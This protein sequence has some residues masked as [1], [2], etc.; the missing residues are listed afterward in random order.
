MN[1][2]YT[3][4]MTTV[5]ARTCSGVAAV[6]VLFAFSIA[7]F[8]AVA[9]DT[10]SE[11][12]DTSLTSSLADFGASLFDFGTTPT[13]ETAEMT[14][15]GSSYSHSSTK[16]ECK[17]YANV[18]EV[19]SGGAVTISW[20]T[21]GLSQIT[22]NGETVT[23][24]TGSKTFTNITSDTLFTLFGKSSKGSTCTAKVTVKCLPPPPAPKPECTLT[25]NPWQI[26]KGESTTLV[27]TTKNAQSVTITSFG[28]VEL[29]GSRGTGALTA[30]TTYTLTATGNGK[31]VKCYKTITVV[32]KPVPPSCPISPAPGRTIVNFGTNVQLR[33]DI[34]NQH[35]SNV[36]NVT[37][38]AGDYD[39]RLVSYDG[40]I[41]R[42]S[43]T[44][45]KEQYFV[46]FLNGNNVV[47][48]SQSISDLADYVRQATNNEKVNDALAIGAI[49]GVRAV[50]TVAG[51]TSSANSVYPICM[52]I[53]EKPKDPVPTCDS[54]TA[55]PATLT[56]GQSATLAWQTTNATRVVINNGVGEVSAT[57]TISVAPLANT[58]YTLTV[59]GAK[60]TSATCT[61]PV[62]VIEK[63]VPI[64]ESFTAAP[65]QIPFAGGTTT[66]SWSVKNATEVSISPTVGAV[67]QT[68]TTPVFVNT[69]TTFVLTATSSDGEQ[70]S[71][72]AIV[73]RE[74]EPE[75]F[76][77]ENNVTFS[78]ANSSVRRG[79]S[80]TLSWNV[81]SADS[82]SISVINATSFTGTQSVA[83]NDTTTYVLSATKGSKTVECPVT[84]SVTT[85]GG[86]G[87]S[88][89]PRCELTVS[90]RTITRGQEIVLRWDSTRASDVTITDDRGTVLITTAGKT[91]SEKRTLL[92]GLL[93]L[94]PTRD[95][96]Y[97]MVASQ[98]SRNATCKVKVTEDL[99]VLQ[100]RDQQ[101]LV[102]GISLSSVPYTGFEAGP[103][104]TFMFYAL[105]VA[106]ALYI[107]YLIV[108]RKRG[109]AAT[110]TV[111]VTPNVAAMKQAES[112]RPDVFTPVAAAVT[113]PANLPT[114]TPVIG[115]ANA[116]EAAP[117]PEAVITTTVTA[118]ENRAHQQRALLSS[119]AIQYFITTTEGSIE[120][121]EALD[122]VIAEA[123]KS[124]PLEDGWM[125][126]NESR[127][128]NLCTVCN[129]NA[130][131]HTVSATTIPQGSSSL[132]EA[133]V[134]GNVVAAYEMIGN[135]PMFA[136]ADAATDLDAVYRNRRGE[137]KSV[138]DLLTRESA[139]LSDEA[140]KNMIAALTSALDGT[141]TD[142]ASAVKMAI[143]KAIK[144]SQ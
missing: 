141:Y 83:P 102:A 95:T 53:D 87:G 34:S 110:A 77:C 137:N 74:P 66:L 90:D 134:T 12:L 84:V 62:T 125:V 138:S 122:M 32:D 22:I 6:A 31:E 106:W 117:V 94:K 121:N 101:P 49:T 126:I 67:A 56:V 130:V 136:L 68:G 113:A 42:E 40:Y 127:M 3:T 11:S 120:R 24:D 19:S 133:I 142:E 112:I 54:F 10:T 23:G 65:N 29:N 13:E 57:G 89:S 99:V 4:I 27:W 128:R 123:K 85:G 75:V 7:P 78:A 115:Y 80:T 143:M 45:P 103:F 71:C 64:C 43:M 28:T 9:N 35:R 25:A 82:V 59:F 108:L 98:G 61:V 38:P 86:G 58:T 70:V 139:T 109:E 81:Q 50:H 63:R 93:T 100:V 140:I 105:L 14:T 97:T 41:G 47:A 18:Q 51:D 76:T 46:Q 91:A 88:P 26:N 92:T 39:V 135:R 107:S 131:A 96:E 20:V 5:I 116:V 60:N 30:D 21:T 119:D 1:I 55:T 8:T 2:N 37:V 44:Q 114:G 118:L 17:I 79:N 48:S 124:Y 104:M 33:S 36:F 144:A 16:V 72:P 52:A 73:T 129:V 132:A 15:F 69:N 111:S